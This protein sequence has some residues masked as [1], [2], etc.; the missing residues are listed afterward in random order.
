M[1][2]SKT[3]QQPAKAG[4]A[5]EPYTDARVSR[6]AATCRRGDPTHEGSGSA[7]PGG[8]TWRCLPQP[9]SVH[10]MRS[11]PAGMDGADAGRHTNIHSADW[12]ALHAQHEHL[13]LLLQ[14]GYSTYRVLHAVHAMLQVIMH[15][16]LLIES[17]Y[18]KVGR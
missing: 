14:S 9:A 13:V 12:L 2:V 3:P 17:H 6:A 8:R 10:S 18:R 1:D 16:L 11:R 4:P 15:N 7:R 5:K